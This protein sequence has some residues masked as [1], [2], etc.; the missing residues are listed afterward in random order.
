[1]AN[2]FSI[3]FSSDGTIGIFDLSGTSDFTASGVSDVAA[4]TSIE[5]GYFG[6]TT[7]GTELSSFTISVVPEPSSFALL[8]GCF[9]LAWIMVRRR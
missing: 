9:G 4:G 3:S 2:R 1:M 6:S 7:G 8:A 5:F